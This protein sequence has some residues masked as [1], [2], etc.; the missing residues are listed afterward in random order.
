MPGMTTKVVRGSLWTM[1][2]Q[3]LPLLVSLV[4]SPIV[5]RLLGAEAY[6]AMLLV[7]LI[8]GYLTFADFGMGMASTKFGSSAFGRGQP[9][10]EAGIIRLAAVVAFVSV[11]IFTIPIFLGSYWI[12]TWLNVPEHLRGQA[13]I[14][15]KI[16][17][18]AL[19]FT[20]LSTVL[21]SPLLAR[22]RMDLNTLANAVPRSLM[23][24]GIV[25][26]FALGGTLSE[27]MTMVLLAAIVTFACI[28]FFSGRLLP[29]LYGTRLDRTSFRPM[30]KFGAGWVMACLA[31]VPVVN[32]E[33]IALSGMVSV[34]SL[35][36]YSV[37]FTLA[38]MAT[39]FAGA[40]LQSLVPAFAQLLTPDKRGEFDML[41]SR[42]IRLN[43]VWLL[44]AVTCLFVFARPFFTIWAG[45]D[46]GRESTEPF[47]FLLFGLFF[48]IIAYI[49]HSAIMAFGHTEVFAK[50]Y[51]IELPIYAAL[52]FW[53][54]GAYGITGAA[55]AW[56][57]RVILDTLAIIWLSKRYAGISFRF[58]DHFGA[59]LLA[60]AVLVPPAVYTAIFGLTI[61]IVPLMLL[62]LAVYAVVVWKFIASDAE[63]V[64]FGSKLHAVL[65]R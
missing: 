37:A 31:G 39:L 29:Q 10:E 17:T 32:L 15:L 27:A 8:P 23:S 30:M 55:A 40:M 18:A 1:A 61:V 11:V 26:V 33:K 14:A 58:T 52:V 38:S 34:A 49:P 57:L 53:L 21:N 4:T 51:W 7:V 12:V 48:N 25:A 47:Y 28:I 54:I 2:G 64:W 41:F 19:I 3:V 44:P 35:A 24:I 13:S 9:D 46:F 42:G 22:L 45:E 6:G 36:Y 65:A 59:F 50:L 56:S 20:V 60:A 16:T 62:S 63:R 5:I 43:V